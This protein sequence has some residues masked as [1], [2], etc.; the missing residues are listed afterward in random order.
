ME[1]KYDAFIS[2]RHAEKDTQIASEIQKSLERFSIPKALQKKTGKKR[3]NR[4]F[5]DVEE[6]PISSNLTEDIEEALRVSE[7]LIVICSFRTS[8]SDWV[9]REIETFL[10]LHDYNK[11]LIL[12]V[13]VE[14]EPDEVIPEILRHDNITHY[15]ADGTFYCKDE[16]VEPLAADYRMPVSRA[17]K[18]E[19]PRL[20]AAMLDC[21]YDEIIRRR[22]SYK[23]TRMFIWT[24]LV[25]A[26]AIA[27]A[28]YVGFMVRQIN[29]NL[30]NSKMNQ[31]RYYASE[32]LKLLD[33]GD[34]VGA[35]QLA[36]A[37]FEDSDGT[38]RPVTS[39]A[40]FAMFSAL[41]AYSTKGTSNAVAV[42]R[43]EATAAIVKYAS[44]GAD[45]RVF[46]LDSNGTLH[47][48]D[49]NGNKET[50]IKD[51]DYS[52]L[53]FRLDK[54]NDI[55]VINAMY[56]ALYDSNTQEQKWKYKFKR[57]LTVAREMK[58]EYYSKPGYI[59]FNGNH[60]LEIINAENGELV[61]ALDTSKEKV[62]E[63]NCKIGN[64]FGIYKFAVNSDFT[65]IALFGTAG[66][67]DKFAMFVCDMSKN[68]WT[69]ITNNS[70]PYLDAAF[71][72][73]GSITV[74]RRPVD[75]PNANY[76]SSTDM[77]YEGKAVVERINAQG[78][79]SW[80]TELTTFNRIVDS[81][82]FSSEYTLMDKSKT[83]V[84]VASFGTRVVILN[85]KDGKVI[86]SYDFMSSVIRTVP[87]ASS[88]SVV[89]RN[90]MAV[91]VP[92][93]ENNKKVTHSK[94]FMDGILEMQL[95][96]DKNNQVS[97]FVK[98]ATKRIITE[99]SGSF[100]DSEYK[101]FENCKD[102]QEVGKSFKCGDYLVSFA[103]S[104]NKLYGSDLSKRSVV[105]TAELPTNADIY[106]FENGVSKDNRFIFFL[107]E[108]KDNDGKSYYVA[109]KVNIVNGTV[110]DTNKDFR[111][112][113]ATNTVAV[114]GKIWSE[115]I[116]VNA[117][118]ITLLCYNMDDDSVKKTVVDYKD[119]PDASFIKGL[120]ASP[121]GR[122]ILRY[123][124]E[125]VDGQPK[126]SRLMIDAETGKYTVAE[127]GYY[128]YAVW[129]D[130]G[131]LFAEFYSEGNMKVFDSDG[132]EKYAK[133]IEQNIPV[134]ARFDG[135]R[136]YVVYSTDTLCCYDNKGNQVMSVNLKH[137][138]LS[139]TASVSFEFVNGYLFL[140]IEDYTDIIKI[141]DSKSIGSFA[142][143][144]C[145]YNP[146]PNARSLDDAIVVCKT[147]DT[148]DV[149][150]IGYFN[151]K[152][153]DRMIEQAK[154]YLEKNGAKM[155]DEFKRK[156]GMD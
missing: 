110:T 8:E 99:Y 81:K 129:N 146:K 91:W 13:L 109:I 148:T 53:D 48:W 151:Y 69:C 106:Y 87:T 54:N 52:F 140:T 80:A 29:I 24:A 46:I 7:Y 147:Y 22:K 126:C 122:K 72:E 51:D 90:G 116:D 49:K 104:D 101:E 71:D 57:A 20:A 152:T 4:V 108:R 138:D 33:E 119:N 120:T 133:D 77:I 10:E 79:T 65:R 60:V 30:Q 62:V 115:I 35:T 96:R 3:F 149:A 85:A 14:G 21:N 84:F 144:L 31:S 16:V 64:S 70:G 39:E 68:S 66:V 74:L 103:E 23:R 37:A 154:K 36:L 11:Q 136:L 142:G 34:R 155:S 63:E 17:R 26:A 2:Y 82:I 75:D 38:R 95:A 42:W 112:A 5:R 143:F 123:M 150:A 117:K 41:G 56:I 19:L 86:K 153:T 67:S 45:D 141:S 132:N 135:D 83:K 128:S 130:Q 44:T 43:Y 156:Y 137:G 127:C 100:S 114:N 50:V 12:T 47:I 6:L 28:I 97:Y 145:I 73:D 113:S 9:R 121:D 61:R 25:G 105:W 139:A 124:V 59:V 88:I 125:H 15:L 111:L 40:E 58:I 18:I 92:L 102:I 55:I 131:T 118:T 94:Y 76:Y 32:S 78:K 107:E 27:F 134:K 98:D 1:F 93:N 89:L